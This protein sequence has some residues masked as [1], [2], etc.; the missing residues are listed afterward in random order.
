MRI[1]KEIDYTFTGLC[2]YLNDK[3]GSKR[4]D[5]KETGNE[6]NHQD[7]QQYCRRGYLPKKYGGHTIEVIKD[8]H[9][10][11]TLLRIEGLKNG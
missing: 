7:I 3:Y 4:I 9:L 5:G 11:I 10:G 6:F 8:E 2:N 1:N